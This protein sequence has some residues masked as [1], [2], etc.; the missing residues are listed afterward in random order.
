MKHLEV[1]TKAELHDALFRSQFE[2]TDCVIEVASSID[3]NVTFHRLLVMQLFD[4]SSISVVSLLTDCSQIYFSCQY[5]KKVCMPRSR[6][7][8][9]VP[10]KASCSRFCIGPFLAFQSPFYQV[11]NI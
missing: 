9:K 3:S 7:C 8:F 1:Q 5:F 10:S 4:T 2:E 11:L 6:A